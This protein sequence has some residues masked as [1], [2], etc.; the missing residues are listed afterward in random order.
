MADQA[1]KRRLHELGEATRELESVI[2]AIQDLALGNRREEY[3]AL[4]KQLHTAQARYRE[5]CDDYFST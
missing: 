5:A 2:K 4:S 3:P 1:P